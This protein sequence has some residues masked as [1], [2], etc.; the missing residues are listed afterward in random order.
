MPSPAEVPGSIAL[1]YTPLVPSVTHPF[2]YNVKMLSL[3]VDG[4]L[5]PVS[6]VATIALH[7]IVMLLDGC[8]FCRRL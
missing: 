7:C 6:Q 5:L 3:A 4:Q 2:Y 8:E 1:Q